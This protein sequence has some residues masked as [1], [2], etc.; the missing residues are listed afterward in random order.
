MTRAEL[1][2]NVEIVDAA[3]RVRGFAARAEIGDPATDAEIAECESTLGA[4]LPPPYVASLREWNGATI[5]IFDPE[6]D[7]EEASLPISGTAQIK[8]STRVLRELM[9]EAMHGS[10][11]EAAVL[12]TMSRLAVIVSRDDI[13]VVL[14]CG[15]PSDYRVRYIDLAYALSQFPPEMNVI[16]ASPDEYLEKSIA[17]LATTLARATYWW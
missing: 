6:T 12:D 5:E 10:A 17:H 3:A 11:V 2:R 16:A 9:A 8:T 14:D 1:L 4:A 15:T 7:R 13:N